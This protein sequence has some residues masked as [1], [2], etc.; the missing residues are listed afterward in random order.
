MPHKCPQCDAEVPG[1]VQQTTLEQRIEA[2]NGE[3]RLLQDELAT[4]RDKAG[5]FDAVEQER[6]RLNGE[7]VELREGNLRRDALLAI[8][9]TDQN[10]AASFAAL[11][12]SAT[13]ALE[14]EARP[15]FDAWLESDDGAKSNPLLAGF[16]AGN[17]G[18]T[19]DPSIPTNGT[20][21]GLPAT[22]RRT[23]PSFPAPNTH[24]NPNPPSTTPKLS[25]GQ[26]RQMFQNMTPAQV[27]AWQQQ[28]G[29]AHG[30][31]PPP[32]PAAEG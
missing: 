24:A 26:L 6:D 16:F 1:V 12:S 11:Y 28:H 19:D 22:T 18:A 23:A 31:A 4:T 32:T 15:T 5:R 25:P 10:V 2:K 21:P 29:Q 8:G 3:I 7:L 30:W 9:V 13:A 17:D 14:S 27:Q 20:P